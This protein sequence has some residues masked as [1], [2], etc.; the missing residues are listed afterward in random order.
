M[1]KTIDELEIEDVIKLGIN[2]GINYIKQQEELKIGKRKDRRLRNTKLLLRNY[3][4]LSAHCT[5]AIYDAKQ[6]VDENAIDILDLME[7]Y[8]L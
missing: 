7:D 2:A 1:S 5:S 4:M 3:R 8:F 6:V